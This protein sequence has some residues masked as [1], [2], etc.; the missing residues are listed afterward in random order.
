[1]YHEKSL[2]SYKQ[3]QQEAIITLLTI[4]IYYILYS[5]NIIMTVYV[6]SKSF[7]ANQWHQIDKE[8]AVQLVGLRMKVRGS[9]WNVCTE[10][11]KRTL[12]GCK[13]KEYH[14]DLRRCG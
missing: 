6:Y 13:V 14:H 5:I 2:Q 1:M 4:T 12:Y 10:E 8:W 3:Q 7:L 11:E 9:W